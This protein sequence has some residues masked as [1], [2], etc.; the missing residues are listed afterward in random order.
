MIQKNRIILTIAKLT[1]KGITFRQM[2]FKSIEK[3][4]SYWLD[5]GQRRVSKENML[6]PYT[7]KTNDLKV[8]CE[9]EYQI[10]CFDGEQETARRKVV[11]RLIDIFDMYNLEVNKLQGGVSKFLAQQLL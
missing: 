1:G 11:M 5:G 7:R 9:I 4:K 6:I 3:D 8:R 10:W 2:K